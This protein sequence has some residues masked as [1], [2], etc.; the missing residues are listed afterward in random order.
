MQKI[1][2]SEYLSVVNKSERYTTMVELELTQLN[3]EW[4]EIMQKL[5]LSEYLR[6]KNKK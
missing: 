4:E 6:V 3:Y 2:V 5:K 1:K